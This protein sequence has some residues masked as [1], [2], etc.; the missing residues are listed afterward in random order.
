MDPDVWACIP[1]YI[2]GLCEWTR[3]GPRSTEWKPPKL[4]STVTWKGIF[5]VI[6]FCGAVADTTVLVDA[7]VDANDLVA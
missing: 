5:Y 3:L 6:Y 4:F 7:G 2:K 1:A